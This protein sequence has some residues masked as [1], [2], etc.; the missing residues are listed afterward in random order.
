MPTRVLVLGGGG[1][2]H[3]LAWKLAG[4]PGVNEVFVA[5]GS[6]AI[7]TEARV[8][9]VAVDPLDPAAVVAVARAT[10][11]EL[12][13]VGPEAPLSVGVADALAAAGIPVFGPTRAAAALEEHAGVPIVFVSVGP[14]RTQT[15]ERAWRPMRHRP[16]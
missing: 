10:S 16:T 6:A 9:V 15:I 13:V 5:P 12:V 1:R 14:E 2:E 8:R 11:A 4:E 7:A 3:A